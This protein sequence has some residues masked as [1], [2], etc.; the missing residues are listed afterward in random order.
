MSLAAFIFIC[1]AL[2]LLGALASKPIGW[3]V[4]VL[5]VIALLLVLLGGV[6]VSI[7]R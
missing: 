1:I 4:V 5:S 3:V 2:I 6:N 7:G